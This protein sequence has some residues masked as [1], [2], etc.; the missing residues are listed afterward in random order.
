MFITTKDLE[1]CKIIYFF[2]FFLQYIHHHKIASKNKTILLKQ[3][4]FFYRYCY[5]FF[6]AKIFSPTHFSEHNKRCV[7]FFYNYYY[8]YYYYIPFPLSYSRRRKLINVLICKAKNF[9]FKKSSL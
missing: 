5:S 9:S 4:L 8:Y 1:V 2:A 6:F 7:G 3:K